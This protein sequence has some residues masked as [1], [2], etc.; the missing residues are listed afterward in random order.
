VRW[1]SWCA[2]ALSLAAVLVALADVNNYR[3]TVVAG[4]NTLAYLSGYLLRLPCLN[5]LGKSEDRSV[6]LRYLVE[7]QLVAAVLLVAIPATFA[8]IGEG[9]IA[10]ELRQGFVGL[11]A[12]GATAPG[13]LIGALYACLYFFGTLIYLDGRENTFCIPL[14]RASSLLAGVFATYVLADLFGQSPPSVAQLFSSGLIIAALLILSPLHH[15]HRVARRVR[16][17][18]GVAYQ[19]FIEDF[20]KQSPANAALAQAASPEGVAVI[21]ERL[22]D[23]DNFTAE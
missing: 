19:A 3:M 1:F 13:L 15:G 7:E 9:V 4:V 11:F 21:N 20:A 2:L 18:L 5:R 12:G 6:A 16:H 10:S 17:A 23:E 22:M 8:L 14:N